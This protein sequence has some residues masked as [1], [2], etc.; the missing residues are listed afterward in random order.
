MDPE[1]N[2]FPTHATSTSNSSQATLWQKTLIFR[3]ACMS[4]SP[5]QAWL[6]PQMLN[7]ARCHR[8]KALRLQDLKLIHSITGRTIRNV[9]FG[10][11]PP[12]QDPPP[13]RIAA[14]CQNRATII[15]IG[16]RKPFTLRWV[17][18]TRTGT[19]NGN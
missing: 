3:R 18:M 5:C 2:T 17:A 12:D 7:P 6:T 14:N 16:F 10:L 11:R 1:N 4:T 15:V 19:T 9:G 13:L 8:E